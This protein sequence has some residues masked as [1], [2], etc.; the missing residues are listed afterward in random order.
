MCKVMD[1]GWFKKR[2]A[3]EE[4]PSEWQMDRERVGRTGSI[5]TRRSSHSASRT[6]GAV[7][8]LDHHSAESPSVLLKTSGVYG[9]GQGTQ[10]FAT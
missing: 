9:T 4:L 10:P 2:V 7:Y 6:L 3:N 5:Y 8:A 1:T